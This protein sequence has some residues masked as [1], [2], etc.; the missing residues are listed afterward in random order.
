MTLY[1]RG[2]W[3]IVDFEGKTIHFRDKDEAENYILELERWL[4]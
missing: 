2:T 3:W 1:K 4:R